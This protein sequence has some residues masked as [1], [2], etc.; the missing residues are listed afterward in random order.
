MDFS[1][2]LPAI[3]TTG[4]LAAALWLGRNLITTRLTRSVAFEFD[5]KLE[6][7]RAEHRQVEEQ[8]KAD[9]R[10]REAQL[11]A[12]QGGAL[13]AMASRQQALDKR[14]LEAVDQ[15]WSAVQALAP[16]RHIATF[17]AL[18]NWER[19]PA[20]TERDPK[21]R[22]F[23][24]AIGQGLE[25]SQIDLSMAHRA[26]PF[27]APPVWAA[28]SALS[29]VCMHGVARHIAL[30]GGLGDAGLADLEALN[31]L[32]VAALPHYNDFLAEHG[33]MA[34]FHAI[35]A[36]EEKVLSEIQAMLAG[37]QPDTDAVA[38]ASVI[39]KLAAAVA[40]QDAKQRAA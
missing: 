39:I 23:F 18:V 16:A 28:W 29:V 7:V 1:P 30:K 34:Y 11:N 32:V 35:P 27:L 17:M 37:T 21:A 15:I 13:T 10:A 20:A 12:L 9:L 24:E 40:D 14:R 6:R 31:K 2:W 38:R 36:L 22:K 19:A 3:S 5:A 8:L 26:R 4:L 33:A 25:P